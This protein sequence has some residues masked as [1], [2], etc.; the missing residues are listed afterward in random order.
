MN[1]KHRNIILMAL[2]LLLAI[3]LVACS[4]TNNQSATS[5]VQP[6]TTS[7]TAEQASDETTSEKSTPAKTEEGAPNYY[8][9]SHGSEGD[10]IWI[11]A[12]NGANAAADLVGAKLNASFHH[13]DIASEKEAI[14]AAIAAGADGI[15]VSSPEAGILTEE[16]ALAKEKGIPV[17]FFN[18]DDPATGRDAYVGANLQQVGA[19]WAQYLVDN[20]LVKSG[21]KVWLPVEVPGAT[22]G[23]EETKGIASVFDPL[24]I[25]YEVFD[26]K[27][28]PVETLQNMVDYL[29]AHGDKID[30]MIG[31]GDM[32]TGYTQKAFDSVGW[33]P[34]HIPVVG[35]GNSLDTA[36]AVKAGYVNAAMWQYPDSQGFMPIILLEMA[37]E[38]MAIGY[39][40]QTF[41]L[42]TKDN[43]DRYI[44]LTKQMSK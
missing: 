41:G 43:V 38:D 3:L 44:E 34:G 26:A 17:V 16:V 14:K 8:W 29:T 1:L 12:I 5:E 25:E 7:Q 37:R 42:Y 39:D 18:A 19:M 2:V 32:V 6:A 24:G 40:V 10:P 4:E 15:A 28:D 36:N 21:D 31:L 13:G 27:Y 35:W 23:A 30:A 33:E 9:V 11:F 20:E 22:Y